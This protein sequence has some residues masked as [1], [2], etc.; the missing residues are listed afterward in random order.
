MVVDRI[1]EVPADANRQ[2][3]LGDEVVLENADAAL[4]SQQTL[5]RALNV[6][7]E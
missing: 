5:P 4:P 6:A 2:I 3:P 1:G 7:R